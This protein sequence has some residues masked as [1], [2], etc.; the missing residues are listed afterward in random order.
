MSKQKSVV[1]FGSFFKPITANIGIVQKISIFFCDFSATSDKFAPLPIIENKNKKLFSA[2]PTG[3][4]DLH[5]GIKLINI[6]CKDLQRSLVPPLRCVL[7][8]HK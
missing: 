7:F 2:H 1:L 8:Y 4:Y 6:I 3:E 5:F